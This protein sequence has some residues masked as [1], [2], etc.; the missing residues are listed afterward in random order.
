M[1]ARSA[2][3]ASYASNRELSYVLN[4]FT[5]ASLRVLRD[6]RLTAAAYVNTVHSRTEQITNS[7]QTEIR[8]LLS[9]FQQYAQLSQLDLQDQ[10]NASIREST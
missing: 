8:D 1:H 3:C 6:L 9:H 2:K 5:I 7:S 10:A 4:R